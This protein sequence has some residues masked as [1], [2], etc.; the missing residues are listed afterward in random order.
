MPLYNEHLIIFIHAKRNISAIVWS[1]WYIN[2]IYDS[3]I[4][5]SLERPTSSLPSPPIQQF[6]ALLDIGST[7]KLFRTKLTQYRIVLDCLLYISTG[8]DSQK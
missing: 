7:A 5:E 3:K 1:A 2:V 8:T 6:V 4:I